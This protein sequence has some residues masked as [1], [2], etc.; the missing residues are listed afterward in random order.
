MAEKKKEE[1]VT[2]ATHTVTFDKAFFHKNLP[3]CN[4]LLCKDGHEIKEARLRNIQ[5]WFLN[6]GVHDIHSTEAANDSY[7]SYMSLGKLYIQRHVV[8]RCISNLRS[9]MHVSR[10]RPVWYSSTLPVK[11]FFLK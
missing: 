11:L 10:F 1:L 2:G 9:M 8:D 7:I 6:R 5:R 3:V 4:V